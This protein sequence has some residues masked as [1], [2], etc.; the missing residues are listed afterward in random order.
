MK[1]KHDKGNVNLLSAVPNEISV[2]NAQLLGSKKAAEEDRDLGPGLDP[3]QS[4]MMASLRNKNKKRGFR[5]SM[6]N[7]LPQKIVF[8][9]GMD[10]T[11]HL[12]QQA[13]LPFVAVEPVEFTP[14]VRLI[15]P[16]E[17]QDKG[18]L[19]VNMFVTSIDVEAGVPQRKSSKKKNLT[20]IAENCLEYGQVEDGE[21]TPT[22]VDGVDFAS[23][24]SGWES[25]ER[26]TTSDQLRVG[27][28][29]GWK[30]CRFAN[31]RVVF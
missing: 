22:A 7:S 6:A 9:D 11:P 29:V 18:L 28:I 17:K 30:V 8:R 25:F 2:V 21:D 14:A 24:E 5:N 10:N 26:V 3:E 12:D 1:R 31:A 16:S 4:V 27:Q 23:A 19:P 15:P 20:R 13:A